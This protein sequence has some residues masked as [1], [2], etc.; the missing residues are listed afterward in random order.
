MRLLLSVITLTCTAFVTVG[1]PAKPEKAIDSLMQQQ[2]VV[3]LSVAVV[4]NNKIIYSNGFGYKE[5]ET[6]TPLDTS[7]LFRIASISKSFSATA[8]MQL[9]E[10]G[11]LSLD[12]DFGSL[13][14]FPIRNPKYPERV[15]TLR[16]VLSH[17]SGIND[18]QGYF[19]LDVI[20]PSKSAT[21]QKCYN[22]YA[23]GEGY[24]YCNLN[25]NMVGAMLEKIAGVRFDNYIRQQILQPLG[26]YG[27]YNVD[28]LDRSRFATLYEYDSTGNFKPS[29]NAYASRREEITNYTMGYTT[30]IFSPTG[31]MKISAPDLARYMMMH[32][33]YGKNRTGNRKRVIK[34]KSAKEMQRVIDKSSGYGLALWTTDKLIPGKTLVGHTGSAYGLYSI[35]FFD[36]KTKNGI[37][38]IT[39]GCKPVFTGGTNETLRSTFN[40]LYDAFLR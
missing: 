30:P 29:A 21:W 28:S 5:M 38:V 15:I 24:Q 40:I 31:G 4:K 1:Q 23:P 10:K 9:V 7:S 32:M 8:V 35:M 2:Q 11:K 17:T 19:N 25:F 39:N 20:N 14:G 33:N 36:P 3:G 18:S 12:N 34:K 16:M 37:V 13:V 22:D 6:K 26:L 27:G